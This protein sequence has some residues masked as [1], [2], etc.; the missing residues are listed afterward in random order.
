MRGAFFVAARNARPVVIDSSITMA[1]SGSE[2]PRGAAPSFSGVMAPV[3]R[4]GRS[5]RGTGA[6][7]LRAPR[8]S[9]SA[10]SAY[11]ESCS[12]RASSWMRV[13]GW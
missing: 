4:A 9:T 8:A 3:G 6:V 5:R 13:P 1:F 12:A 10:S 7:A 2:A 11:W